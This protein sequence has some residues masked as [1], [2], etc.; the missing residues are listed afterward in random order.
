L[1]RNELFLHSHRTQHQE[2]MRKVI[3]RNEKGAQKPLAETVWKLMA[4][5]K[6]QGDTRKGWT[7]VG[8]EGEAKA[9]TKLA[10]SAGAKAAQPFV[11][12]P[13]EL[14]EHEHKKE[15]A[16]ISGMISGELPEGAA[17]EAPVEKEAAVVAEAP[18][19]PAQAPEKPA[20]APVKAEATAKGDNLASIPNLGPKAAEALAAA[21]ITT[22]A[23]LAKAPA[24]EV[25]KALDAAGMGAKRAQVPSWKTKAA[26]LA[27]GKKPTPTNED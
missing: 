14:L 21:G 11:V 15:T 12:V 17:P 27:A 26:D 23:A 5:S 1:S 4:S 22:F 24:N 8:Y 10:A 2:R 16:T 19:K 3:V 7:L 6:E 25:N 20:P 13:P 18:A 9:P